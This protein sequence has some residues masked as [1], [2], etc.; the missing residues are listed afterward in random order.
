[1][2]INEILKHLKVT[3]KLINANFEDTLQFNAKS[4]Q[5]PG[6]KRYY[7]AMIVDVWCHVQDP[8]EDQG[9]TL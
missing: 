8:D 1:M 3:L 4:W 2:Y 7:A 9:K 6:K 5:S